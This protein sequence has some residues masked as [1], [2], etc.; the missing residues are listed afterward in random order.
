MPKLDDRTYVSATGVIRMR[1]LPGCFLQAMTGKPTLKEWEAGQHI[2]DNPVLGS[3]Y[4]ILIRILPTGGRDAPDDDFRKAVSARYEADRARIVALSYAVVG[5]A[6]RAATARAVITGISILTRQIQAEKVFGA[7]QDAADW[8]H[9][10][11][12]QGQA[13]Q[14]IVKALEE[15]V[16]LPNP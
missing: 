12:P 6:L 7:E 15:L 2:F 4:V 13:P 8:L 9:Q 1:V 3:R 11:L 16:A 10:Q 5:P 14:A